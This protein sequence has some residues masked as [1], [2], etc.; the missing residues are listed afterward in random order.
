[1]LLL[2]ILLLRF[3]LRWICVC[4]WLLTGGCLIILLAHVY[5]SSVHSY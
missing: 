1:M 2:L 5:T 3:E 4:H